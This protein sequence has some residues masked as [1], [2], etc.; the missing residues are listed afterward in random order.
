[1]DVCLWASDIYFCFTV[2]EEVGLRGATVLSNRI[3]PHVAIVLEATTASDVAGT[4]PY[5]YT[6]CLGKGPAISIMDRASYS[7]KNLNKFITD[8]AKK[9]NIKYQYKKTIF[10]GN[11]AGAISISGDGCE[12]AVISVPCRYIHSPACVS[13]KDDIENTRKLITSIL[14]NISTYNPVT[15]E[16]IK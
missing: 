3:N 12:T 8:I 7:N 1:M 14:N 11:D 2:Q 16:V 4:N 13:H 6:T 9:N 15:K 10:G 5:E